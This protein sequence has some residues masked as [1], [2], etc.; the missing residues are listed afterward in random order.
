MSSK[1]GPEPFLR[2]D[3]AR[4]RIE[5]RGGEALLWSAPVS[6][7]ALGLGE[8]EGSLKTPR[9]AHRIAEKIGAGAIPGTRFVSRV[10]NGQLWSPADAPVE[11]DWVLTRILWLEGLEPGNANSKA[12]YIYL[13][14]TNREDRIGIPASHGCIRLRNADVVELFDRVGVG[15]RVEIAG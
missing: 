4:Q 13:H 5:L 2:V 12:R 8:E 15:V 9:G 7:A 11:E 10:P 6:T 1:N 14:G 3:V